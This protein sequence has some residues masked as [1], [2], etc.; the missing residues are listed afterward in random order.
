[1]M[2]KKNSKP[3]DESAY[4]MAMSEG[5]AFTPK[6]EP[7]PNPAP[8]VA[9]APVAPIPPRRGKANDYEEL[10]LQPQPLFKDRTFIGI[11]PERYAK[12][13]EIIKRFGVKVSIQ[14]YVDAIIL[15]HFETYREDINE[16]IRTINRKNVL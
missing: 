16:A 10:F 5:H 3:F 15:H 6:D 8:V 9:A 12:L 14:G 7:A 2:A 13:G 1:M 4:L 11:R